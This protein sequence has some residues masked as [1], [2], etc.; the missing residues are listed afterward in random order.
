MKEIKFK[1]TIIEINMTLLTLC[2]DILSEDL[3]KEEI[4]DEIMTLYH[5][6]TTLEW[7]YAI[8]DWKMDC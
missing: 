4:V 5:S 8:W 1:Q 7:Y 2:E 6:L 3:T